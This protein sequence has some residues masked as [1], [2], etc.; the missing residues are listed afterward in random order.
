M[1][2][3]F[4]NAKIEMLGTLWMAVARIRRVVKEEVVASHDHFF[5]DVEKRQ[6][7]VER[8]KARI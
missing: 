8:I 7:L 4:Y 6:W 3:F 2:C 1:S 5:F